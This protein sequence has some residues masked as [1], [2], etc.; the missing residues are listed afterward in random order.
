MGGHDQQP[1]KGKWYRRL[2]VLLGSAALALP[3]AEPVGRRI[4]AVARY[5]LTMAQAQAQTLT[6]VLVDNSAQVGLIPSN[7]NR[8]LAQAFTTGNNTAGYTVTS[9]WLSLSVNPFASDESVSVVIRADNNGEPGDLVATLV[10]PDTIQTGNNRFTTPVNTVLEANTTYWLSIHEGV[11]NRASV[12]ILTGIDETGLT[13]WSIA[14]TVLYRDE[15]SSD[16][17]SPPILTPMYMSIAGYA[18]LYTEPAHLTVGTPITPVTPSVTYTDVVTSYSAT[19]LPPGLM[20]DPT[21]GVISGTPIRASDSLSTF[22]VT[23]TDRDGASAAIPVTFPQVRFGVSV[24]SISVSTAEGGTATY[25][26]RLGNLPLG[27]VTITPISGD[28]GALAVS[29]ASLT[30]TPFDWHMPRTVT[31]TGVADDDPDDET[32][33][34]RHNVSGA[35]IASPFQPGEVHPPTIAADVTVSVADDDVLEVSLC[36]RTPAVR[37]AI[38]DVIDGITDCGEVSLVH[39]N[40]ITTEALVLRSQGLSSLQEGDFAGLA[41]LQQ[42]LLDNND[43]SSLPADIFAGLTSLQRLW[44]YGNDLSSLPAGIF[45]GLAD[46]QQLYLDNNGLSSLPG[47]SFNGLAS[48]QRLWLY[49]NELSSLPAGIFNG[50]DNLQEL[51]LEFNDLSSLDADIFNGLSRLERLRVR[52]NGLEC[53]PRSLPWDRVATDA[54]TLD[55]DLPDCFGVSLSV[56]PAEVEE[57]DSGQSITVSATLSAGPRGRLVETEVTVSVTGGTAAEDTDFAA[58]DDFTITIPSGSESATGTFTLAAT[59]DTVAEP[60][61]ETV[62]VSGTASSGNVDRLPLD[63]RVGGSLLSPYSGNVTSATVLIKDDT[64]VDVQATTLTVREGSSGVYT[65]VM[66]VQPTGNVTVTPISSDSGVLSLSPASLTFTTANWDTARTVMV[67]GVADD[68]ASDETAAIRH[69]VSGAGSGTSAAVVTVTV[70]DD[71][72]PVVSVCERTPAVR[73]AILQQVSGITD[74]ADVSVIHLN[75]IILLASNRSRVGSLQQNDFADLSKL[76][77]LFLSENNLSDLPEGIFDGLSSLS[78]L[79]LERNS[80]TSLDADVFA[81]ASNLTT[82]FL[83]RNSLGNLDADLFDGLSNLQRLSLEFNSLTSLPEAIFAAASNLQILDLE[84][85]SLSSL[86]ADIFAGL[87]NLRTL[88]LDNN[89]L[90]CLPRS[91]PWDRVAANTL[92]LDVELPDCFG[93]SLG[94]T[95]AQVDEG[96]GGEDIT[97]S[98]TLTTGPRPTSVATE[99]AISVAGATASEGTDFAAAPTAFTLTIPSG[100]ES[101][102]GT[103]TLTATV[104]TEEESG[105]ETVVVSG[106]STSTLYPSYAAE[107]GSAT[108]TINDA[109]VSVWP[110]R[111]NPSEGGTAVYTVTLKALPDGTVTVVPTSGD[112]GAVS[113]SPAS[114]TFTTANWDTTRTVSVTAVDDDDARD[115]T[116][117]IRH[118]VSGYGTVTAAAAVTVRVVDGDEPGVGV[119]PTRLRTDEGETTFYTVTLSTLPAGTVTIV[120]ANSDSGALSLSPASLT[121]TTANWNTARTV[122]VTGVQDDDPDDETV[123][124]RHDVSGYG[125]IT[126]AAAVTVNVDDDDPGAS[127]QPTRLISGEGGTAVYTVILN[128][129]PPGA[130]TV[131]PTSSDSGALTVS[132]AS[133]TFTTTNWDTPRTVTVAGVA[134]DDAGDETVT[135]SHSVSGYGDVTAAAVVTVSVTDDEA[136]EVR[137]EPTR[138]RA[139]EAGTAVY[140][141]TLGTLPD[142]AV[143]ITPTSGDSGAV[144]VAPASLTFTTANWNMARTVTVTGVADDDLNNETATIGHSV[145]GY[146]AV[147]AAAALTVSVTD[148]D[149]PEVGVCE[150]TPAVRNAILRGISGITDCADVSVVH[151]NNITTWLLLNNFGLSSLKQ[152]DFG[153]LSNLQWLY[154]DTNSLSSLPDGIFDDLSSLRILSLL[155]NS[156]SSL[157]AD[158]FADLSS[159]VELYLD[160]NSLSS[161]DADI[162]NVSSSL[163]RLYL[164]SNQLSSLDEGIFTGLSNLQ[165]LYLDNNQLS[166]LDEDIFNDPTNLQR[167]FLD[168]NQLSSLPDGIFTGLTRLGTLTL[169]G[170]PLLLCL[171][172]SVPWG[173]V[174]T[175][176]RLLDVELPDCFGVSLSVTPT[177][178]TEGNGGESLTVSAVLTTGPRGRRVAT[179]VTVSVA[180]D[181]AIEGMDFLAMPSFTITIP[182]GSESATGTFTLTATADAEEEPDGKTVRLSGT[183]MVGAYAAEVVSSATVTIKDGPVRIEP[184]RVSTDEGGTAT[185]TVTLNTLLPDILAGVLRPGPVTII[186]SSGDSGAVTVSPASLV[187]A[188]ADRDTPQTVTVTGVEDD[189]AGDETV[190]VSHSVSGAATIV[191]AADVTVNVT[192]DDAPVVSVCDRT[193][194]VQRAILRSISL[195]PSISGVT[196]CEDVSVIHLNRIKLLSLNRSRVGSLQQNDFADLSRLFIL[197]LSE[198]NLSDLPEG[199]FDGLSGLSTLHLEKNS[200]TSLPEDVFAGAS[201]LTTLYLERNSLTSLPEDLFDGLSTLRQLSLEFNSLTSLPE[202]VFAGPS[203]L[204]TLYLENNSLTSL[205][206]DIFDGLSNLRQLR[207]RNNPMLLCLPRSVPWDR[208]GTNA[209]DLDVELPDCFGVSLSVTP[210]SVDEGNV[211]DGIVVTATLTT[212]PRGRRVATE[213]A[214]SVAGDTASEG[215]DFAAVPRF[216][217]ITIP[218]G[219][220]SATGFFLLT[221]MAD[222]EE[223]PGGETVR[224]SGTAMVGDYA[225]EVGSAMV[226][227]NDAPVSVR[228]LSLS[229]GEGETATYTLTLRIPPDNTVTIIPTS[230]DSG[231]VSVAP[232]SLVFTT[233]NWDTPQTLTV[234]TLADEDGNDETVTV[235]HDVSGYGAVTAAPA[236]T[237]RVSDSEDPGVEVQPA[238]LGAGEGETL[239]YTVTLSTLPAGNVTVTPASGDSGAVSVAPA[240]LTF[241]TSNW[242]TARTVTVT[243]LA[244]DDPDDEMVTIRHGVSGYG[245]V[246]AAPAVAVTVADDDPGARIQPTSLSTDEGGTATYTVVLNTLPAGAVTVTPVSGD[247]GALAV[248]TASLTFTTTNWDTAQTVTVTGVEDADGIDETVTV[249]HSVSGY[250]SVSIGAVVTVSVSDDEAPGVRIQPTSLRADEGGA[251]VYTMTLNTQPAGAVTITPVSGDSGALTVSPI[252]LTFTPSDW[253]TARTVTVTGRGD[254][255]L[256]DETV[257]IGHS[258]SGYGSL[259]A[260]DAVTVIVT[261]DDVPA[262]SVC[263]RTPAVRDAILGRSGIMDCAQVSVV[264]LGRILALP[265]GFQNLTTLQENDFADLSGLVQLWLMTNSLSSLPD[266]IFNGL[267]NLFILFLSDNPGISLHEGIFDGL[268]NLA[269]LRLDLNRLS[270]LPEGIFDGLTNLVYLYLNNND[271]SS[272]PEDVFAGLSLLQE[273]HLTE[274]SLSS[275][276]D[277]IFAGLSNLQHLLIRNNSLACLPRS[278]PWDRVASKALALDVDLPDCFGVSL[279]VEPAEVE[280]DNGGQSIAVSATLPVGPRPTLVETEVTIS[281]TGDTATEDTDFTAMPSSFTITIP[282]GDERGTGAFT[283]T[284]TADTVVEPGGETV[285]VSGTT[286]LSSSQPLSPGDPI[287]APLPGTLPP[288]TNVTEVSSATVLIRDDTVVTVLPTRLTVG[289][290]G[291]E[292]YTLVLDIA[293]TGPVTIIPTGSDSGAVSV[294]PASMT[295]TTSDW[296]TPRTVTVTA[297]EDDD[298]NDETVT[299]RHSVSGYGDVT[300][301]P[302]VTVTVTDDDVPG[303][304][305]QPTHL[306]PDEG[307]TLTYTVTLNTPPAGDVTVTATGSDSGAV[308]MSPASMTFTTAN[309]DTAQTVTVTGVEDDDPNDEIVSVR[310]SV[311]GYGD[312]TTAPAVT[313]IVNDDDLPRVEL[314]PTTL[315]I[316]EG[317]TATYTVMISTLPAGT[318]TITLAS[319]DSGAV[320]MSPAS[321]TFTPSNWNTPRTVAV[322]GVEDE[323]F[324]DETVHIRHLASGGYGLILVAADNGD[325][326]I[327]MT[328]TGTSIPVDVVVSVADN[329]PGAIMQPTRVNTDEGG[330]ATYTVMLN[331]LPPGAVTI[332]PTSGDSGAVS[333]SPASLT[334]TTA[335][336]N[337]AQTVS[338]AGVEDSDVNHETVTISHSVSGYGAVTAATAV[339]V[340]VSDDEAPG[341]RVQ[342]ANPSA[343][344]GGTAAYIVTLNAL[345]AGTVTITPTSSDSGAVSLSPNRLTF[346]TSDW[347][348]A[349][350]VTVTGVADDDLRDE[351]VTIRHSVS[352]YGAITTAAAVTVTVTDDDIPV[353]SVCERTPA[354]RRAILQQ[355]S[356]ITDCADV[357]VIHLNNIILLASNRSRVGSLQQNDFA[358]LSKLLVLF[359]SENNL[360]DL[361]E[362]IFDGLSSLSTLHLERNSLTSL[363][364]DV[365]AGASNLTTLFLERNSLGNLDADLF[366]GLSNLQRLSLEFNSLTSLPEAI[367]AAASNLQI[368]DLENNS[369]SSLPADIFAGLSNLRTL[370]LDNNPL[371]CLPRSLPWDR[372]AANTLD[373]DVELPDCFGVSLGVT[374]AQVDEGSGGEDITVSATLTAGPRPT[375]VATEVAISVAGDTASEGTDFAAV[376]TA[377]TLT[378]PSG[379][380]SATGTFTL[381]A[382]VDTEE[383]SGGETVVVSGTSTS[384]LYPSYAAEVGSATVTINDALVSVWPIRLNPSE[385]G[386]AVYTV[387]LKALPDGTVTVVPTSGD[388]GAV[389]VSPASLTFTT[390]NWDTTRTVTVTGVAD[391]DASNETVTVRHDVSG[392][393][394]VTSAAAVMVT[395][396]DDDDSEVEVEPTRLSADEGGTAVYTLRLSTR[397]AGNVTI[398]PA[399]SDSGAATVS[400]ASVVFTTANWDTAR[401]VIVTGV[402]DDDVNDETV[403][404]RHSVSGYGAVSVGAVVTISVDDDD[405]GAAIQP[406]TLSTDEGGSA[407]YTVTLSTLPPGAVTI[408]PTSSDS[409]ALTVSPARLTF[410]TANWDTARTLTVTGVE[411]ADA[412]DETVT[413]SHSISGY[414]AVTAAAAVTVTVSD[415][416]APGVRV[417]PTRVSADE[418]GTATYTVTLYTQPAGAVTITPTSGD[419][420]AL[421]VTPASLTFT[422]SDWN[423]ART[424]TVTGVADDDAGDETVTI[425][426][427]VSGYATVTAAPAVTVDVTDDDVPVVGVCERTPAVRRAILRQISGITDCA[428]VSVIHLNKIIVLASNRSRM[429]SLKQNDFA[430]LSNLFVLFLSENNL[431]DLPEGIFDGLS[432]LSTLHLEKNSLTS[433]PEDV[434][435]GAS[436]LTTLFLDNNLLDSLPED[437]FDGLSNLRRLSLE[438]VSLTRLPEDIFVG[439]SNLEQIY[440]ENNALSSLPADLFAGLSNLRTLFLDGNPLLCLPRSLPWDRVATNAFDLDVELPD[441]FGVSLSVT[442]TQV[443]EGNGGEDITVTATLTTGARG[444]RVATEVAVSVAGDTAGDT[445]FVAVP[446]FTITIPNGSESATGTFTLTATADAEEEPDE[447]VVVSGAAMV[448]DYAAAVSGA[449]VTIQDS[450]LRVHPTN[451]SAAEGGTVAYTVTLRNTRILPPGAIIGI[452][453]HDTVTITI[454]PTSGDSGA[455]TVSPARLTFNASNWNTPQTLTVTALE[456]DDPRHE[457]VT[458]RHGVSGYGGIVSVVAVTVS[459]NDDEAPMVNVCDRTPAVRTAILRQIGGVMD[460]ENVSMMALNEIEEILL[461]FRDLSSLQEN[462]FAD[463][464]SLQRLALNNNALSSLDADIFADFSNLQELYLEHNNLSSLDATIFAGFSSLE[465]LYLHD[466]SLS[467][468]DGTIFADL[469]SLQQLYLHDNSLSSLPEDIFAGLSNL[470]ELTLRNNGLVCLSGNLPWDRVTDGDLTLDLPDCFGVSLSVTP[471]EVEEGTSGDSITVTAALG[472]GPRLAPV[473]TEVTISITGDTA[474]EGTD[475]VPVSPFTIT[476]PFGSESATGTFTLTATA[477]AEEEPA[478]ETVRLSGTSILSASS[479]PGTEVSSATVTIK[480]GPVRVQPARVSVAEGG[481]ATYIVTLRTQ[482]AAAVTVTPSSG[483][484]DVLTLSPASLTL[485]TADWNTARTV[486]VAALEDDDPRHETLTV[487]HG[488]SGAGNVVSATAVTVIVTD[489]D[490]PAVSVCD[491]TPAVRDTILRRIGITDCADVS[492]D[493]LNEMTGG[494][495]VEYENLS[496][497]QENDFADLFKLETLDLDHNSLSSLPDG[498]FNDLS[499]LTR[500]D[501]DVNSFTSLPDGIFN[502]L[503][504]LEWLDLEGNS[505]TGL[506]D[507]IFNGLSSLEFLYLEENNLLSLDSDTFNDL[508]NLVVLWLYGSD[509]SSL[510]EDIFAGLSNLDVIELSNNRLTSLPEGIFAGL[511]NLRDIWMSSNRLS[512]LPDGIFNGI[513][514]LRQLLVAWNNNLVCLPRS[515]D[516]SRIGT[517][518]NAIILDVDL[519]DCFGV[520]LSVTPTEVEEG[521]G[522]ESITVT[523]TLSTGP[524]QTPVATEVTIS[525]SGDTATEGTDF[526]PVSPFTITIPNRSESATGTFTLTATTDAEAEADG[527]TVVVGG[528]SIL[529]AASVPGTE[530]TSAT[531][532]IKDGPGVSMEPTTLTVDEG[533]SGVY[534]LVLNTDPGSNVTVTP[535]SGDSGALTVSPASLVFT[536]ATWDTARTLTVTGVQDNDGDDETVTVS[537]SVSG[538]GTVSVGAAVTVSVTDDDAPF[539]PPM[540]VSATLTQN[541]GEIVL[542]LSEATTFTGTTSSG[543]LKDAFT[544]TV[545]GED[546]DISVILSGNGRELLIQFSSPVAASAETVV[547]GYDRIAAGD[548]A[549]ADADGNLLASFRRTVRGVGD[550]T[551][552]T[553]TYTLPDFLTVGMAITP[554]TPA[555][556]DTDITNY[557]A[558]D[559]PDGLTINTTSGEISGTP[560]TVSAETTMVEVTVTDLFGNSTT[561]TLAFPAVGPAEA[562]P[563]TVTYTAPASLTVGT[564]IAP[565]TPATEDTDIGS[566]SATGLPAGL[567]I[568]P[569][570]GV[571]SGTPTT[572]STEMST[573]VVTVTD[574][575]G[576]ST[577]VELAFPMVGADTTPPTVV[578]ATLTRTGGEVILVLSEATTFTGAT[579]SGDLKEA[580]TVT[581]DGE[582]RNISSVLSQNGR[583]LLI[584]LSSPVADSAETVVLSYDRSTAEDEALADANG[585]LLASFKRVLRGI[586]DTTPPTV[587]Y[588]VPTSLT[589]GAPIAAIAPHTEDTDITNTSATNLPAGLMINPTTGVISGTPTTVSAEAAMVVV[590]V[591]DLFGNTTTVR[592]TFPAVVAADAVPPM[593]T[594]TA[595]ASLMVGTPIIPITPTVEGADIAS[596]SA[597]GLPAGL[598]IDPATGVISG[599]PT[600]ASTETSTVVVTVTDRLGS[601][602]TITL[603]FPTVGADATP[604]TVVSVTLLQRDRAISLVLSEA[605]TFTGATTS[606]PLKDAFTV[607]VDGENHHISVVLSQDGRQILVQLSSPVPASAETVVLGYDRIVAE[608]E[609]PADADGNLLAS[610]KRV[611]RGSGDTTPP[612]VT[613]TAPTSLTVGTPIPPIEPDTEDTDITSTSATGLPAGLM[614]DPTTGVISGTPTT[615]STE[616]AAVVVVT[617]LFG[618]ST[619]V[620]L[621]FPP[622]VPADAIPP[623]VT[624]APP[625]SLTVGT[626][627]IPIVPTI[628]GADIASASATGLPDGLMIDPATG[629]ISGTPTT[630]STETAVVVVVTVTDR[631]GSTTTVTL[632]FPTV[633][634]DTTFPTVVSA[635]LTRTGREIS[636]FLSET[637]TFRGAK[638]S[639]PLKD[640]FTVTVDGEEKAVFV[641]LSINGHELLIRLSSPV[642]VSAE[643]VVLGYDR[644]VAGDEALADVGGN[645]LAS[646]KRAVRGTGDTT[647]PTVT[648]TAPTSLRVET[649][650]RPI[651]PDTE[652]TD[653]STYSAAGLPAGLM[654]NPTTGEISGTPTTVSAETSVVVVTVAD[655]F[656]NS[657]TVILVFPAVED[658]V[659]PGVSV[660]PTLLSTDEGGTA[661]YTV[662]LSTM[663]AGSV[664]ITPTSGDSGAV[665]VLPASLVFTTATW[666]TAQT[667]SVT[668]V[669]DADAIDETVTISHGVGGYGAV[670]VGAVVTVSVTDG[671]T[672]GVSVTPTLLSTDEGGTA[673]YTVALSTMPA[674]SVTITPTSGDSGAVSVTPASL[675]FTTATWT[676]AQTVSVTGVEDADAID[677]TVTISH[678][679]GGYGAVSVGAVVTVSVTDGDTLGVSVTPTL[680]STDE[681]GTATYTVAL[682]TMPAGSVTITPT[683]GDSGAVSV[684]PA[685]LVFTTATWTTAQTVSVTGVEDADAIDETVTISHGVGGYGAVSVG[686]VVTVSVTDGDTLGVSVTPTLLSTDEGGTATYT[687]ALSTMPAGSVT[688]TPTSGDSGAVSVTP[689]S[690]VFTTATWTTA[691]TV[692]VTGVKDADA[693]DE[694]VT[695]SHGV[696]GY[697]SLTAADAVTVTVT[698]TET[699]EAEARTAAQERAAAVLNQV[700]VPDVVQQLTARTTEDITSRLNSVASGSLGV[701]PTTTLDD[702]LADTLTFLYGQRERLEDGSLEWRQVISGRSF[703]FPLSS[704]VLAQGD[705][706]GDNARDNPFS[707]LAMWGGADYSSYNNT[708][709]GT[710][711]DG[712]G[713]SAIIG[714]DLRPTPRLVSGLAMASSRWGL[715]YTT[716][717]NGARAEGTYGIDVTMVNPYVSWW[718]TDQLSLWATLGYGRGEVEQTPEDGVPTTRTGHLTSWAGGVRFEVVPGTS[719]STGKGSPLGLAFKVDGATSS[720]LGTRVQLAR[721]AAEVSRSFSIG[722]SLLTAALDLGWSLRS[723]AD[724]GDPDGQQQAIAHKNHSGGA[725]LAGSLNWRSTDG[726]LSATVDTR[727]LLSGGDRKEWGAGGQ[728]RLTSSRD[729]EGLSLTLQPSFGVTGTRL[730]E[731]WSLSGDGDPAINNDPPGGRLDAQLA[732]SFRH[733]HALFTP[734]TEAIWEEDGST[735][736]AGLRYHLNPFLE[737]EF[738]GAHHHRT[739]AHHENRFSLDARS[740]F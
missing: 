527:E 457:T 204:E 591:M 737:L 84:N 693:I 347:S 556:E 520:S 487:S 128:T 597:T 424:V 495:Y 450:P 105:G 289:E 712:N 550:T 429:D 146:G 273:L 7:S 279:S 442:P 667:V 709:A 111:L 389:S 148:D 444:R 391:D 345:S 126:A 732:Y 197:F 679:V 571:I 20:I 173:K 371:L 617:D 619:T 636:L 274:N 625:A 480:D 299:L 649:A 51:Y 127:I 81:G 694:T 338:V 118:S 423:T 181:T 1:R 326:L 261:D 634:A 426:H 187:F 608:D 404:I 160:N 200:L 131:T 375:S 493:H 232:A 739:N 283:L 300:A 343:A 631:F 351:T 406:T 555:T 559:L 298:P 162:F 515:L 399:S 648:Y 4:G 159:L 440:L 179:E 192:D 194:A 335:N 600:T 182:N 344:E 581:V 72:V 90:L 494:L 588:T 153:D 75:N 280:E 220:E 437:L 87:S 595:P 42:L 473:A 544:V 512:S 255:N 151:L 438:R 585:N 295:F 655:L 10:N 214:I 541:G 372:V 260:A 107:V 32:V 715:D 117:T 83:E 573:V 224:L 611:L 316:S 538:Y 683:S 570:T 531:V 465:N 624:Y 201:N 666:T 265:V 562:I 454:T 540:V 327:P 55:V 208:V 6:T 136:P 113:V 517:V 414:G 637:T 195:I 355:V 499:S 188:E 481:T 668:G 25:T 564:A 281:V 717:V 458:I 237:V 402:E 91:L 420:G 456:D 123:T 543:P 576:N 17:E 236:V 728:L 643:T 218:S 579:T 417:Q 482:P 110:I 223:E 184:A 216:F 154:L 491:R 137:V 518:P 575:S 504:N 227:I 27:N 77:I 496:S 523:A 395:V 532:T 76:R 248:S 106:T 397:P 168:N 390:A 684:S 413:V 312:V 422:T 169:S 196:S 56:A 29:P 222:T 130:V 272:L 119:R 453:P 164:D 336:W 641:V 185:Y 670:S 291:S 92:D 452:L 707:S 419:S 28:S 330:T 16:W 41:N 341:V 270:S 639:G 58:V 448:G 286:T 519:P 621:T 447:T 449:T 256:R 522:G 462:D 262:V 108:V 112:S 526:A 352:G 199:I 685:S 463:L 50:L 311:S 144:S 714:M 158:I 461:G 599:T 722:K 229:P 175:N 325:R 607:T 252:S 333:V 583:E 671:D 49:S 654:I 235:R 386:T 724:Q 47:G 334:F 418:A 2:A 80:L 425:R 451:L 647:P 475:F 305:V 12:L 410:T 688:I 210:R 349:R 318:V 602:A 376:P 93:V 365:F 219:S 68:D 65:L 738:K 95:P 726:S 183:A 156:L 321:L 121:F 60:G 500:L 82:L 278:V 48:L 651:L 11:S 711:V 134:D 266:G 678:G 472:A 249:S 582:D 721:L 439:P 563:P 23:V 479:L 247:T 427:N 350:T 719:A 15:E 511:S 701:L 206:A 174:A 233:A 436:N 163:T 736:G 109:L 488:V 503:T 250:G 674:G 320:S 528:T 294:S 19:G 434:F 572:V 703:A 230:G 104:D 552:P 8:F 610:F 513:S 501:L 524:R 213:V 302:A 359:L 615:A 44:L 415:D 368:L 88:F 79:H 483:D 514:N 122:S 592:L 226:T 242:N 304:E 687:V 268:S 713:F 646:F 203:N 296:D 98:A 692:S 172:R 606:G 587:T 102:T 99:V 45:N 297:L 704:L 645:G 328:G 135:V 604:P 329:T 244:D 116:V 39:L 545:D 594:Y 165:E 366:D 537:H 253:N 145:S 567:M 622:V 86:P 492:V 558:F 650:I 360:S 3:V 353:V 22:V 521:A 725:E 157:D 53:L 549:L 133:L 314:Q 251:V 546:H 686:A 470:E 267:S 618:N 394:A 596:A 658:A 361:P 697:G 388:S 383:E 14:N 367:F 293:P 209:F 74:C 539:I 628:E 120:P 356:G 94:V 245:A 324:S 67:T 288:P 681:G 469:S 508:S 177:E 243:A 31:V 36:D 308:S 257:I 695:I 408:V 660:T 259:T 43:L 400:P 114:L 364:E 317:G 700:V 332:T 303:V 435:A 78:T 211:G 613:Y 129:L 212:G 644:S 319:G 26:L 476:I 534:T 30:F 516:W 101:A 276:P 601:T 740:R 73:R 282:S 484:S 380:E 428:D 577:R 580:F 432:R 477:D 431:S 358:D 586:G 85:N 33:T 669:E 292:F 337:T 464:I 54:L 357:S 180:G 205:P 734:Y 718:A 150:R 433:L 676:T 574:R 561:V 468:L 663:P 387:T 191:S 731:L 529:S 664:T 115:E 238:R 37:S 166:S 689:A 149:V 143:T 307:G 536:T 629:V 277:S 34:I 733:H 5:L 63:P 264:H 217:T 354:V 690:L 598:M 306:R 379:S 699:R 407:V 691:Q 459:V 723:V 612:T 735:Y 64:G 553:V 623:M 661:T 97:V 161:L 309:W 630:A 729:G 578:S 614:I 542:T 460:C 430:D 557:S 551:P 603:I 489:D 348:T 708:I 373:L 132:P 455:V 710:N 609:A 584:R 466:N 241:T 507:G 441:C 696:G 593:V 393:G 677:E 635:V 190:A 665:S 421:S 530:V 605:T 409:G 716:D 225:A 589:V 720:F 231:A 698:D 331:T 310:H 478:G 207:L 301:A 403:I 35:R 40:R 620:T 471:T 170:N 525:L 443:E 167:L 18:N 706:A 140:T 590:T 13:G 178:V 498:I 52:G 346:T 315:S 258:V 653:I 202:D 24:P 675:V 340:T 254:D 147:T 96:N 313:V 535:T 662:A 362:G 682:S 239:S 467:S 730:N 727:V 369:L 632:I 554:I 89:P 378:I 659:Q 509:L 339:T 322:T 176:P 240:S 405:P 155:K 234:T 505:L 228:P 71:D 627:I 285:L 657:A 702:A 656:G 66:D 323:D 672:L 633:G 125:T 374:P 445:D 506:P 673:T 446:R 565:I 152:N 21:T 638:T 263:D 392:Y 69:R 502:G 626:P 103:F 616:T 59:A 215:M 46:L 100:S 57:N 363:P 652:D 486:T 189:D 141:V 370:F 377:F 70:T 9:V 705:P 568:D 124:I 642:P 569:A 416:E 497:L 221:A 396:T 560:T 62:L 485:T 398:T 139:D 566:Y 198:N 411:D 38:L 490:A 186:P 138:V 401:T 384:T 342:P 142:G 290:G 412:I 510:P 548:E 284:A 269:M 275:L 171:P 381:T 61:G 271:L 246:T 382:T 680:L 547:L 385:G 474:T 193:P 287:L 533:G 640:A